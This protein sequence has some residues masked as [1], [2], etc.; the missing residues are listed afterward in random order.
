MLHY[1][2]KIY[3][4]LIRNKLYT[5][6]K[7]SYNYIPEIKTT[8][9]QRMQKQIVLWKNLNFGG[10]LGKVPISFIIIHAFQPANT[11]VREH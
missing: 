7:V 6:N 8:K 2:C 4:R 1:Y 3:V 10:H 9:F 5:P 11:G